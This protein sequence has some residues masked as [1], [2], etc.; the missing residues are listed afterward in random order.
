MSSKRTRHR[1]PLR[2]LELDVAAEHSSVC[3]AVAEGD[4][5]VEGIVVG[6][7][8]QADDAVLHQHVGAGALEH[9][10]IVAM[11]TS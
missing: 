3:S 9:D 5:A 7:Q 10:R 4:V 11:R 6:V 1:A 2:T 8:H